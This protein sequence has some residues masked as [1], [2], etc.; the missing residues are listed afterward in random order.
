MMGRVDASMGR[1]RCLL[2]ALL[3]EMSDLSLHI[4]G[5]APMHR[6]SCAVIVLWVLD[7]EVAETFAF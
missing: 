6:A 3:G 7:C 4:S 1:H 2:L 5:S